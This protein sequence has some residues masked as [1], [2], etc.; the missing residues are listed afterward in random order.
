LVFFR[1]LC[2]N[3]DRYFILVSSN[4][5]AI[6]GE[7]MEPPLGV[8]EGV[9]MRLKVSK[10]TTRKWFPDCPSEF[11]TGNLVFHQ[12]SLFLVNFCTISL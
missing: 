8:F 3:L 6:E 12:I 1:F 5:V 4:P 2:G 11:L 7:A 9:L 10:V